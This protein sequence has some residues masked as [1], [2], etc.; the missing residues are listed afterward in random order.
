M[1]G[2]WIELTKME[3]IKKIENVLDRNDPKQDLYVDLLG[4]MGDLKRNYGDYMITEPINFDEELGRVQD[5]DY[6]LCT[7]LLTMALKEES[8][9]ERTFESRFSEGQIQLVLER[10]VEILKA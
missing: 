9:S 1:L 4:T 6:E 8:L 2:W 7:A 5:A 10:M 3:K